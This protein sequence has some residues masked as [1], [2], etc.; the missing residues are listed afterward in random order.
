MAALEGHIKTV[1][2]LLSL[3]ANACVLNK[4][5]QCL[6]FSALVLPLIYEDK[7]RQNK[8]QIFRLLKEKGGQL[9]NHQDDN[10]NTILHQMALHDFDTLIKET[11]TTNPELFYIH[12]NNSHYPIHTAILNNS[13]LSVTH[14]L[15]VQ[16]GSTLADSK[17]WVALHYAALYANE[18]IVEVCCMFSKNKDP[19]DYLGRSPLMLAAEQGE[20]S[21]MKYLVAHGAN[22]ELT[23]LQGFGVLHY[24]VKEGNFPA[25]H[26]LIE[27]TS[28]DINAKD[29]SGHTPLHISQTVFYESEN[30][31]KISGLL[32]EHGA[33][34][35]SK[36]SIR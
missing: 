21:T 23:D 22:L 2:I 20:L 1:E 19:L 7:Q 18:K 14:L 25:V 30:M 15:E 10:G 29:K 3:G 27:N 35:E 36:A 8:I 9:L 4:H 16:E 32:L 6:I 5:K 34:A 28:V 13:L 26:W 17:G 31:Q 24:A 33:I 11:L 12:N